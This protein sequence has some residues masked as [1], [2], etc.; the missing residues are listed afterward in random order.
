MARLA[1]ECA[2]GVGRLDEAEKIFRLLQIVIL[3]LLVN[4]G[5]DQIANRESLGQTVDRE[6]VGL[7][8]GRMTASSSNRPELGRGSSG[9]VATEEDGEAER[10]PIVNSTVTGHFKT[11]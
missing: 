11:S 9:E 7:L 10:G 8:A 3:H 2:L 5:L 1:V 4:P 6:R